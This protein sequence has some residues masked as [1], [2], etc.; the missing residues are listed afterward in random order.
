M[1]N[2][3]IKI[4]R[5]SDSSKFEF[6]YEH[7][8]VIAE[9]GLEG[10]GDIS[11]EVEYI[12]NAN[13]A[14][15]IINSLRVTKKDRS[16]KAI[17][18]KRTD[19]DVARKNVLSFFNIND[20]F[21][22]YVT[23]GTREVF[24]TGYI[25]KFLCDT[26]DLKN[27]YLSLDITFVFANPFWQSVDNYGKNIASLVGKMAFPYM[28]NPAFGGVTGGVFN[29]A[30]QVYLNNDGDIE[31]YCEVVIDCADGTVINP[32]IIINDEY[33]RVIDTMTAG[34]SIV[35]DFAAFPPTVKKNGANY[36][37]H[38]DRT[39]AFDEMVLKRGTNVIR[40][41]ADNGSS[42]MNVTVYYYKQYGAV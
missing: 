40:Y 24:A 15:G 11:N 28:S 3:E 16:I 12:D 20:S 27:G 22:V 35:M 7:D 6:G 33:V 29:Y 2:L 4:V 37:G 25:Y 18:R 17:Y 31:T 38:C 34:D 21:K 9:D 23:Y 10:F 13:T 32:Q 8:W 1:D 5:S 41:D 26:R 19:M 39:S 14:G 36:M 30:Q 42:H